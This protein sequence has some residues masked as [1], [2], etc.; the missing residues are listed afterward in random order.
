[1]VWRVKGV[2]FV[3]HDG[4]C[5]GY[6]TALLM[7]PKD[8]VATIFLTN[9]MV[10]ATDYA[11]AMY[12]IVGP[13]LIATAKDTGTVKPADL[14]LTT[15]AGTY[16]SQPWGS[17]AAIVPWEDGLAIVRLPS[18]NPMEGMTKLK[19]TGEHTF[20]RVRAD[21]ELMESYVFTMG[22][23]GKATRYTVHGNHS[24]RLR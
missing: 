11:E 8:K 13:A 18:R 12:E 4:S 15:Y 16:G 17:E 21:G 20:K 23:D 2:S 5:P 22:P 19:K 6:R 14:A 1:M 9:T 24:P 10:D 3:G 7:Q